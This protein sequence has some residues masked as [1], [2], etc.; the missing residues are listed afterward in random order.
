[1]AIPFST[2]N[3]RLS[4]S[5]PL[6][7]GTDDGD[8]I[9][10]DAATGQW[11]TGT[12][13]ITEYDHLISSRAD[14]VAVVAPVGG[15]FTLPAGSYFLKADVA[16]DA[17]ESILIDDNV[18]FAGGGREYTLQGGDP[19]TPCIVVDGGNL[20]MQNL[21]IMGPSSTTIDALSLVDGSIR[22]HNCDIS[23]GVG[24]TAFQQTG[25]TAQ[26]WG[27]DFAGATETCA[28]QAGLFHAVGCRFFGGVSN[29]GIDVSGASELDVTL[30]DCLVEGGA[31]G[32]AAVNL[33]NVNV[34]FYSAMCIFDQ[35][36]AAANV[37][38]VAA[39]S[40]VQMVGGLVVNTNATPADGIVFAGNVQGGVQL[41]GV[42]AENLDAFVIRNSGTQ[43]RVVVN[44]CDT[45]S[46]VAVGVDWATASIPT[47]GLLELG[48]QF[49]TTTP[50]TNHAS[51][52]AR[53]NRKAN[54]LQ[55]GLSTE[56]AIVP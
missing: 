42:S 18:L 1:M 33:D 7:E 9:V 19:A 51:T 20:K 49:D 39:A 55:S 21:S 29:G 34:D 6:I 38:N 37:F 43:R 53:V 54:T 32:G 8:V 47:N 14:L 11:R 30:V 46:D 50:F 17:G 24:P 35:P 36:A 48:N 41:I 15:V 31:S 12:G 26:F 40:S 45:A 4:P 16:L 5:G 13:G 56:T 44:G 52:D 2:F 10:W 25:G 27:C 28:L 22:A 3:L 23:S